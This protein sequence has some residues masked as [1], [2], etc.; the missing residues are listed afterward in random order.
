MWKPDR[1]VDLAQYNGYLQGSCLFMKLDFFRSM[2][3][4][5]ERY[6]LY[7]EDADLGFGSKGQGTHRSW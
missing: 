3:M 7:A 6:F 1:T 4:L 5:D 2:G